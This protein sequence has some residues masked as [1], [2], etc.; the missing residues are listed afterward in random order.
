MAGILRGI[1]QILAKWTNKRQ[2]RRSGH[3]ASNPG[4]VAP[5]PPFNEEAP[6]PG[7]TGGLCCACSKA[8]IM[9]LKPDP[10]KGPPRRRPPGIFMAQHGFEG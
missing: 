4:H 10:E 1:V 9:D 7:E 5:K 3:E 8:S 2:L 6:R